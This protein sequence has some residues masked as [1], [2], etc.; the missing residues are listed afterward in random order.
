MASG[1]LPLFYLST[2]FL[3]MIWYEDDQSLYS[4]F[5]TI[6]ST[7]SWTRSPGTRWPSWASCP[8][9]SLAA[10]GGRRVWRWPTIYRGWSLPAYA[11]SAPASLGK[12]STGR[13]PG[14]MASS[15]RRWPAPAG[16]ARSWDADI[17]VRIYRNLYFMHA[18][19]CYN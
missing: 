7:S 5:L 3:L 18:C 17:Y 2:L 4:L 11:T 10:V 12:T 14:A 8:T 13:S 6:P 15:P 19:T 16:V 1:T 9:S